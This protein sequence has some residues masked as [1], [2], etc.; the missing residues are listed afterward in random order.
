MTGPRERVTTRGGFVPKP[1]DDHFLRTYRQL[2]D[3]EDSAFDELEH[4][5]EDGDRRLF[6]TEMTLW[7][8]TLARKLAFLEHAGIE[9]ARPVAS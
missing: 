4:A 9:V 7:Q 2:L 1:I 3:A 6:D 8:G 5:C